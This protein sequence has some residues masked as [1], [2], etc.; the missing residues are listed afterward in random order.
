MWPRSAGD[1]EANAADLTADVLALYKSLYREA[2][3]ACRDSRRGNR[4]PPAKKTGSEDKAKK[5]PPKQTAVRPGNPVF[6]TK[7]MEALKAIRDLKGLDVPRRSEIA[8]PSGGP[9]QLA[10][11]RNEDLRSMT[12]EQLATLEI[13]I[14]AN[15]CRGSGAARNL[16]SFTKYTKPDYRELAPRGTG[17]EA[18][19]RWPAGACRR[20]MVF[21]PP[22]HGKSEL[23]SPPLS[24][25]SCWAA[26][27]TCG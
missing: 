26:I 11:I 13:E 7:A 2:M 4:P 20:L 8:G 1:P 27:P 5:K 14:D 16:L 24:R 19:P 21:M 10:A 6:L 23:V 17:G 15:P 9:I 12:D 22:Q 18:G 25:P 3:K